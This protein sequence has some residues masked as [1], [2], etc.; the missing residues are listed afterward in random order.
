MALWLEY[1][2]FGLYLLVGP[3]TWGFMILSMYEG[4]RRMTFFT[5]D[6]PPLPA[7]A[8]PLTVM[9]PARNE[10]ANVEAC[11]ASVLAQDYPNLTIVVADDRSTDRTGAILDALAAGNAHLKIVH[12]TPEDA[13]P[14]WAG[15]SRALYHA[16]EKGVRSLFPTPPPLHFVFGLDCDM[17]LTDPQT[18][19]LCVRAALQHNA[20]IFTLLPALESHSFFEELVLPLGGMLSSAVNAV[21]LTNVDSFKKIAYANG[22]C[23]MIRRDVYD[24]IGGHA[25]VAPLPCEDVPMAYAVKRRGDKVRVG[26]GSDHCTVRMY[27]SLGAVYRGLARIFTVSRDRKTWPMWCSGLFLL[28]CGFS[29]YPALGWTAHRFA[30]PVNAYGHWG[31]LTACFFHFTTMT[32]QLG[33]TYLWSKNRWWMAL[34]FP[35]SGA[36]MLA[37]YARAIRQ[38]FSGQ[39]EWRGITYKLAADSTVAGQ[40]GNTP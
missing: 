17:K 3:L 13:Y 25:S 26:W 22:Q 21:A 27:D 5:P 34:L 30:H 36:I 35:V 37:T 11:V 29:L 14:G 4:R 32:Y 33:L 40:Q 16:Y 6:L 19:S 7:E 20:A 2:L 39:F 15:K 38:C 31:W 23:L 8:P 24:A 28:I 12:L 1:T 18:L 10:E 9:I